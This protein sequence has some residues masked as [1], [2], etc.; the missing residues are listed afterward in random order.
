[1]NVTTPDTP[2]RSFWRQP[3]VHF[4]LAGAA[5]FVFNTLRE[6]SETTATDRITVSAAQ[7]ER[8]AT[9]WQQ[10]WGRAP[11]DAELQAL[12]RDYIKDEIYYREAL[13]LGLDVND[14]VIRQRLRQKMEFLTA[15][16]LTVND[17]DETILQQF[18]EANAARY[19]RGP[20]FSFTQLYFSGTDNTRVQ[21]AL[22]TLLAGG[23]IDA[24]G[25]PI[26]LPTVMSQADESQIT[27]T[28]GSEFYTRLNAI[29]PGVWSDAVISGFG[30]HLVKITHK[31][32]PAVPALADIRASVINDWLA[33]QNVALKNDAYEKLRLGYDIKI[34][35]PHE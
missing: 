19:Q 29:K 31:K 18:Y 1:M 11:D 21:K 28:F 2:D 16:E 15:G 13:K 22:G 12:V 34:E 3:L 27:R 9:V 20:V 10:T 8:L 17:I 35:A 32:A 33:A 24:L 4:L 7:V 30:R 5:I 26:N 14:A 6:G 25:D 23:S